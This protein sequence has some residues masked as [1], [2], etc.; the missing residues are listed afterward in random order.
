MDEQKNPHYQAGKEKL[1]ALDY[2]GAIESFEHAVE[3]NPRS[4]LAHYELGVLYDQ[5]EDDYAAALYHY[6]KALKLRPNGY[7]AENIRQRHPRLQTGTGQSRLADGHQS[8]ALRETE[9]L[10]QENQALRKQMK[11]CESIWPSGPLRAS[12]QSVG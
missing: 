1:G 11:P 2:K 4:A 8:S 9:R 3:D 12:R 5:R 6:N 7:P 10:R